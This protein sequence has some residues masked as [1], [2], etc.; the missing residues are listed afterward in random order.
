MKNQTKPI[1][2]VLDHHQMEIIHGYSLKI[3][4][5]T[6]V[7]VES[8]EARKIFE[9]SEG[10]KLKNDL[11]C[12]SPDLVNHAISSCPNNIE[13]FSRSGNHAFQLGTNQ[14]NQTY[15]GLGVTNTYFQNI[16]NDEIERF[17]REHMQVSSQLGQALEH[18]DMI[19]T[20]GIEADADVS[21]LDLFA[22]L[23]MYANT[24]KPLVLLIS[25]SSNIDKVFDLLSHMHGDI[26]TKPFCIPYVNPITPLVLNKATTDKMIST[27][28]RGLPLMFSNYSMYGGSTPIT[29]AG[30]LALL[31]AELLAGLVFSQLVQEGS[32]VIL[33]SLPAAFNMKTMASQYTPTT[34]VLNLAC[35]EMMNFYRIPHCGTS[36]SN[37][38][39][40]PDL[41]ASA[42]LWQNHLSSC[43]GK[44]GCAPFIGG[45]FDSM[46]FSPTVAVLSDHIIGSVKDFCSGFIIDEETVNLNEIHSVGPGGNFFTSEQTL[47]AMMEQK[48][49]QDIWPS[50]TLESWLGADRPKADRILRDYTENLYREAKIAADQAFDM[51]KLG[52]EYIAKIF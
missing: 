50:H 22:T 48:K 51:I 11:V 30:S 33:G 3:L 49:S 32:Q 36:G 10:A 43:L 26:S 31:N 52:E 14:G 42:D 2:Q 47:T 35:A 46:A 29:A 20:L 23:D 44:I 6:G 12:I 37:N 15:F 39:W 21:Q 24:D 27:F 28:K 8:L 16:Q 45:N 13:I 7:R 38:A 41:L 4:E 9:R 40:G 34:Y 25:E 19:S 17:T 5:K 18:I 1:L